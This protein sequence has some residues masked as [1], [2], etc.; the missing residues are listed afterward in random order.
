[1]ENRFYWTFGNARF[2]VDALIGVDV[3]HLVPFIKTLNRTNYD[4]IC[5]AASY[6][7][8]SNNVSHGCEN[9]SNTR[10]Q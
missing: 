8:L 1:V 5:I 3:K 10:K 2:A 4:A 6:A 7:R 9:L